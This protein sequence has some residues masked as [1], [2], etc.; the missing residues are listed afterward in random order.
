MDLSRI[1]LNG[2][3][4]SG[5][6][7]SKTNLIS[8]D[9]S[10]TEL[11]H[12]NFA[13]AHLSPPRRLSDANF[14]GRY[15]ELEGIKGATL[16]GA[17]LYETN[18][19]DVDLSQVKGLE[20]CVH[21]APSFIDYHTLARSKGVP[22]TFWRG[23]GVP[24]DFANY[25]T[26]CSGDDSQF[27]TCFISY[28][29]KDQEFA[30]RLHADLQNAGVRCWFAPHDLP[31]GAKTWDGI[32]DAIRTRDRV[33]LILSEDAI[34]SSWVEDE[35]TTAFAEE[36]RRKELVLFPVRLDEVVMETD[37]PWASKLRDNRNIGDFS[38]WKNHDAYKVTFERILRD[39][40]AER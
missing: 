9:L 22:M 12:V 8:A 4:L 7:F 21:K 5:T 24:D 39:L 27:D 37:E 30:D 15:I 25:A 33:L 2:A 26:S 38:Q 31:I 35:V 13:G 14:I 18:L 29:S 34:A 23:C 17:W 3:A 10:H 1:N 28:S 19:V 20:D 36:H 6:N 16:R 40:K 11:A 32:D